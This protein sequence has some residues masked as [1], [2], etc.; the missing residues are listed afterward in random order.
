MEDYKEALQADKEATAQYYKSSLTRKTEQQKQLEELLRGLQLVPR[1]IADIA[2]GGGGSSYHLGSLYP[3]AQYTLVDINED[4]I[5]LAREATRNLKATC[6]IGDIY[7]LRLAGDSFDLV[8]CWQTLSWLDRPETALH[9]LVRI[10][11][12]GG[13]V[14]ASSLFNLHHDV[15]VYSKVEDHTRPSSARGLRYSYNTYSLTSVRRWVADRAAEVRIHGFDIPIDLP[16]VGRGLGTHTVRLEN[17]KRLQLSAGILLNWGILE[18][19]K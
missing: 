18:L 4:A 17:G 14:Y 16:A 7:D 12:P 5:A 6:V 2:C 9:E 10:C 8:V 11:K 13:R 3:D 19:R 1:T 15:D